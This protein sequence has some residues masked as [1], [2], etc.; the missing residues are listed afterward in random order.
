M[1]KG[2]IYNSRPEEPFHACL[3]AVWEAESSLLPPAGKRTT[4]QQGWAGTGGCGLTEPER[5]QL[6]AGQGGSEG[7][8]VHDLVAACGGS[9]QQVSKLKFKFL[10][11]VRTH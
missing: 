7:A 4:G 8:D 5:G 2:A 6:R 3:T 11:R 9:E 10:G 1:N